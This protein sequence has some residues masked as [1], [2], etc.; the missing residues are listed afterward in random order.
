ML[1][2][3]PIGPKRGRALVVYG[4]LVGGTYLTLAILGLLM[5]G[6][7]PLAP[8]EGSELLVF[9]VNP[10]TN[11]IHLAIGLVAVPAAERPRTVQPLALG[12]GALMVLWG[13][14]GLALDGSTADV[15]AS[16]FQ[17]AGLHLVTGLVGVGLAVGVP[18]R[19]PAAETA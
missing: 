10:L 4:R 18:R 13:I 14:L 2:G 7:T 6:L 19:A 1:A 3:Q 17:T 5:T 16:N 11:L 9:S 12:V 15:F 8:A